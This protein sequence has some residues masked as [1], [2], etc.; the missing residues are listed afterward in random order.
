VNALAR[1]RDAAQPKPP[2]ELARAIVDAEHAIIANASGRV[3]AIK[4]IATAAALRSAG[5]PSSPLT[6]RSAK[7]FAIAMLL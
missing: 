5:R 4:L 7:A 3:K 6:F 1:R 2:G